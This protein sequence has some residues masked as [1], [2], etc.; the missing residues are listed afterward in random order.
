MPITRLGIVNPNAQEESVLSTFVDA[1]LISVTAA[2]KSVVATPVTKISIW[3]VP[4]GATISAQYAYIA[5]NV[6]LPVGSSFETFRFAANPGDTLYVR[7]TT[8]NTSFS[9]NGVPQEDA[10][11]PEN[12]SQTFTN[13]EIR[14]LYNTLYLDKG[15]TA[16]RRATAEVGYVRFNTETSKL[17][18]KTANAWESVGTGTTGTGTG[19]TGPTGPAGPTGPS[20]GPTGPTGASA[21]IVTGP[22]GPA[23]ANGT[24]GATGATGPT[25][26]AG[27][28]T[29]PAGA[30]GPTGPSGGP[31][32][33]VGPAGPTGATGG[34]GPT[35]AVGAQGPTGAG[36]S[37]VVSTSSVTIGAGTKTFTVPYTGAF[38][39]GERVRVINTGVSANYMAGVITTLTPNVI[40]SVDTTSGSG[41]FTAWTF[42]VDGNVGPTGPSG[43]PTGAQGS[44]GPTGA[45]GP[46]GGPTGAAGATGATGPTGSSG[47]ITLTVTNVGA[48]SYTIN[49]AANP[50]LSFIRGHRYVINVNATGHPFWIQTVSGAY[51]SGNIYSNGVTNNGTQ[52]GTIIFEVPYDAP[53]LYYVCQ[54]HPAM[55]GSI[56]VSNLGPTGPTGPS[57]GPTGPTGSTGPTGPS[58]GPTGPTGATGPSVT[59]PTG[60]TGAASTVTG[61][62]GATGPSVTGPTGPAWTGG[63]IASA[64]TF[65]SDLTVQG[66]FTS[67]QA[68]ELLNTKTGATGVV[69]H[70]FA[71]GGIFYHSS[72]AAGFTANFTNVPTTDNRALVVTLVLAQGATAYIPSAVQIAGVSQTINWLGTSAPSGNANKKDIISFTLIRTGAAW[73]VLG[74]LSTYG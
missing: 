62:T 19:V 21:P 38:V 57:G 44:T 54:F 59:G 39:V 41:T 13:K 46:S 72:I 33:A 60:A 64:S 40:V 43:G 20:G 51:S 58:G 73:T 45:T 1:H 56:S 32:G 48:G 25:G 36:Y 15:T 63:T 71:T 3:I 55:A 42:A 18:V 52:S 70:D 7:S 53:Q 4:S 47:G 74:S 34:T 67:Q 8:D 5:F 37:G 26:P 16:E 68:S 28:P 2:N 22:T 35:G 17:E 10:A 66:L 65:S 24:N 6:I 23:G 61:P 9:C 27:G 31:T 12:L 49:G 50:T 29:G 11:Q 69:V 14:G 30:T